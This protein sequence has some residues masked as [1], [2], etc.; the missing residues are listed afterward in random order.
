MMS[1]QRS[2]V[3]PWDGTLRQVQRPVRLFARLASGLSISHVTSLKTSH[4]TSLESSYGISPGEGA[5]GGEGAVDA[6][7]GRGNYAAGIAGALTTRKKAGDGVGLA[8]ARVSRDADR[9]RSP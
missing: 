5:G 2:S 9:R 1:I 8:V 4:G 3:K 7:D 6:V